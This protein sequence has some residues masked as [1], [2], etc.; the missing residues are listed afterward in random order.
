MNYVLIIAEPVILSL[1]HIVAM[2]QEPLVSINDSS[3]GL[4]ASALKGVCSL[5]SFYELLSKMDNSTDL[6]PLLT[7]NIMD[8]CVWVGFKE[9]EREIS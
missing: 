7:Q 5:R 1:Q 3:T 8:A 9:G 6:Y 2:R 4:L